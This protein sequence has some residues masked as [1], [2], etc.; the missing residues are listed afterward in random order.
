MSMIHAEI[1]FPETRCAMR[2]AY[3]GIAGPRPRE[4]S[5]VVNSDA[6]AVHPIVEASLRTPLLTRL[7]LQFRKIDTY[8]TH[9]IC[10]DP[11]LPTG[12]LSQASGRPPACSKEAAPIIKGVSLARTGPL[13]LGEFRRKKQI[14][15]TF[16]AGPPTAANQANLHGRKR[17]APRHFAI[18][19]LP[20]LTI[21]SPIARD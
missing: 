15:R 11:P 2:P 21:D 1:S 18:A 17:S 9:V 20:V 8:R 19:F 3:Q 5:Y 13:F 12:R 7:R 4:T 16:P 6:E 10:P 14:S